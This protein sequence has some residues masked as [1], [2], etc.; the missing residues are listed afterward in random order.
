MDSHRCRMVRD[1][2]K[3]SRNSNAAAA[4]CATRCG[5]A[6]SGKS[7]RWRRGIRAQRLRPPFVYIKTQQSLPDHFTFSASP[8]VAPLLSPATTT[9]TASLPFLPDDRRIPLNLLLFASTLV[10]G[11][12]SSLHT[13]CPVARPLCV[14]S[15]FQ[16]CQH[17]SLEYYLH[18][19]PLQ[20]FTTLHGLRQANG[21]QFGFVS[22]LDTSQ[23]LFAMSSSPDPLSFIT[24]SP[25][26]S[27][28]TRRSA[29]RQA[30]PLSQLSPN[31]QRSDPFLEIPDLSHGSPS[32]SITMTTPRASGSS[33]WRIKVTVEAQPQSDYSQDENSPTSPTAARST[34]I[35]THTT[36]VPLNDA[37][38]SSPVKRRGRPRKSD[39][40][41]ARPAATTSPT[42]KRGRPRKSDSVSAAG[43]QTATVPL[44]NTQAS[45]STKRNGKPKLTPAVGRTRNG[46]PVRKPRKS[47]TRSPEESEIDSSLSDASY[48]PTKKAPA[49]TRRGMSKDIHVPEPIRADAMYG[50][51]SPEQLEEEPSERMNDLGENTYSSIGQR[52]RS[53]RAS[54]S[55][56]AIAPDTPD[57]QV[58]GNEQTPKASS[59]KSTND[60]EMWRSMISHHEYE[61][62]PT[63]EEEDGSSDDEL[64]IVMPDQTIGETTMLH[65]EE[66]SMV[67][68]HSLPSMQAAL[69]VN[70]P[71]NPPEAARK[72]LPL[73]TDPIRQ[74]RRQLY[75]RQ[76]ISSPVPDINDSVASV[77]YMPSS[78]PIRFAARTPPRVQRT[79]SPSAPP[80]IEQAEISPS[81]A[82]TPKLVNVVKA[83]IAL[84]GVVNGNN[85]GTQDRRPSDDIREEAQRA[86]LDGM[87][88]EFESGTRRELQAGL[89]LGEQLAERARSRATT[90]ERTREPSRDASVER[91]VTRGSEAAADGE[92]FD[93]PSASASSNRDSSHH[94]L[95]TPEEKDYLLP[96][97]PPPPS[98]LLTQQPDLAVNAA[99]I[100]LISPARSQA[101]PD[102]EDMQ[103]GEGAPASAEE[104]DGGRSRP[105][106]DSVL[107]QEP[108]EEFEVYWNR[109]RETISRMIDEANSS[110]V[111]V[112]SSDQSE[113]SEATTEPSADALGGDIWEE[114][115]SRTSNT[116]SARRRARRDAAKHSE[117]P[118]DRTGT[119]APPQSRPTQSSPENKSAVSNSG[120][121]STSATPAS[122]SGNQSQ[123]TAQGRPFSRN[124]RSSSEESPE[125]ETTPDA[126]FEMENTDN[127]GM[128]WQRSSESPQPVPPQSASNK[129]DLSMLMTLDESPAKELKAPPLATPPRLQPSR[130]PYNIGTGLNSPVKGSPL[131]QQIMFSSPSAVNSSP[132]HK[133]EHTIASSIMQDGDT[134]A[135]VMRQSEQND[136]T[137]RI[138]G[139]ARVIPPS[140]AV[141]AEEDLMV[142]RQIENELTP[143]SARIKYLNVSAERRRLFDTN[144]P[145]AEPEPAV[146]ADSSSYLN[147][148]ASKG[149]A[150]RSSYLRMQHSDR[151]TERSSFLGSESSKASTSRV[152]DAHVEQQPKPA[153][154]EGRSHEG[155][156]QLTTLNL[157]KERK[158][159]FE[160]VK[161]IGAVSVQAPQAAR[162]PSTAVAPKQ[163][164]QQEEQQ[165]DGF[166]GRL[167]GAL[168]TTAEPATPQAP[169]AP[170]HPLAARYKHLPKV[171]PWTK[172]HWDTLDRIYQRYKRHPDEFSPRDPLHQALLA[173]KYRWQ[174]NSP[175]ME[176]VSYYTNVEMQNW[177]YTVKVTPELLVCCAVFMQL[178]TLKDASEYRRVTGKDIVR[179]N[180]MQKDKTGDP[181]TLRDVIAR[182]FGVVGG[183]MIRADEKRGI[184][185]RR[186]LDQLKLKYPWAPGWW[187]EMGRPLQD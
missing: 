109:R 186:D 102:A 85:R 113:S 70:S 63:V 8:T 10:V 97:P 112:L 26:K 117:K 55:F 59:K 180:F 184:C 50:P 61:S 165:S 84:Q 20:F 168:G 135:S 132:Y 121:E 125:H 4:T 147:T 153:F 47:I 164:E 131:K 134:M 100:Q 75:N 176:S 14:S 52:R 32:K 105:Y 44:N 11:T 111:I 173:Q 51:R 29:N 74:P 12:W 160:P 13:F 90:R 148:K 162:G 140:P 2:T 122:S 25:T 154:H 5:R 128:F 43:S 99:Q 56:V 93:G 172:T 6:E 171:A 96:S 78:P 91:P 46:T 81:K 129:L 92:V 45:S 19:L 34:R 141:F 145:Q 110:E 89:R 9:T 27:A 157:S 120:R 126:D 150:E 106:V 94:R 60:E 16:F 118:D 69:N 42:K 58:E 133:I 167:W 166:F 3:S 159:L 62:D 142:Q 187:D 151:S 152:R 22:S 21:H 116:R 143:R 174:P 103:N 108:G 80:A 65:S 179:G 83:G 130:A 101:S 71:A 88:N 35:A 155:G 169:Q 107:Q 136:R 144:V 138:S 77:S 158:P 30:K 73:R 104:E 115:G 7:R 175:K 127:T 28:A 181:I 37:N 54:S 163:D 24:S 114:E 98:L 49:R 123:Q 36:T 33:P 17:Y 39:T 139:R 31:V 182:M 72:L 67:S 119:S 183:E 79:K 23:S 161:P 15:L 86:R 156:S 76:A 137:R 41:S 185:V 38:G 40:L 124:E 87:F 177:N 68:L 178:L 1:E 18:S 64:D 82:E 146:Q 170:L 95:P 57:E 66:F 53:A 48:H 149:P